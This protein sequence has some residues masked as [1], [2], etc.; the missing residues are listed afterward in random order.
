MSPNQPSNTAGAGIAG[1]ADDVGAIQSE[2]FCGATVISDRYLLTAA[3]CVVHN[4]ASSVRLGDLDLSRDDEANSAP[5]DYQIELIVVHPEYDPTR[6]AG[7]N[8][9]ALL[10]TERPIAF[11][12]A[13][14]PFCVPDTRPG[15]GATLTGAGF[16]YVNETT[17]AQHLQEA[18]LQVVSQA[19]CE[20]L[21]N[22]RHS[23]VLRSWYP[24]NLQHSDILCAGAPGKSACK[25]DGGGPLYQKDES[26]RLYLAGIISA[27]LPCTSGDNN[28]LPGFYVSVADHYHFIDAVLYGDY[29][30]Y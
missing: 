20:D 4:P 27:G 14:F 25:G 28:T 15:P 16:G 19:E 9:L 5:Q 12:E 8:D 13:V 2:V 30:D 3:H 23:E 24:M 6:E 11:N 22:A 29:L 1:L 21:Y 18:E 10:R 26:G 17:K 7:Y